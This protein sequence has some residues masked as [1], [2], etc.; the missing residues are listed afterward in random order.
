MWVKL[1]VLN[2]ENG[3]K[4]LLKKGKWMMR[5]KYLKNNVC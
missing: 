3:S 5:L 1:C 2:A 4:I